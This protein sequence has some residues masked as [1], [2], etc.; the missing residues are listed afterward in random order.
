M[1]RL[2]WFGLA[3]AGVLGMSWAMRTRI[4]RAPGAPW[5]SGVMIMGNPIEQASALP[6]P[7]AQGTVRL[8]PGSQRVEALIT[9][10]SSGGLGFVKSYELKARPRL[11][12]LNRADSRITQQWLAGGRLPRPG[13]AE[14]LAGAHLPASDSIEVGDRKLAVVGVLRPDVGLLLESYILFSATNPENRTDTREDAEQ[15]RILLIESPPGQ[16]IPRPFH[17][18]I[19][20]LFPP[21]KYRRTASPDPLNAAAFWLYLASQALFLLGGSG[22]FLAVY[23]GLSRT[24]KSRLLAAPLM[25]IVRRPRLFWAVHA[26]YFGLVILGSV[27]IRSSPAFQSFM[28][29]AVEQQLSSPGVLGIA[30]KAYASQNVPYAAAV[31]FVINMFLGALAMI[32]LPAILIPGSGLIV[33]VGRALLWGILLAPNEASLAARMIAH[34]GTLLLEGEGYILAAFFGLLIP[35]MI[36]DR[37]HGGGVLERF[38]RGIVLNLKAIPLLALVLMVAAWYEAFE[39]IAQP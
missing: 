20:R 25:E 8:L 30:G 34:S 15:H 3:A 6:G 10:A 37:A 35:V 17:E 38:W 16:A 22:V 14:V 39:V 28:L 33:P 21:D 27:L 11:L 18:A 32:T 36:F 13:E 12:E 4:M 7:S 31:T 19:D 24:W 29:A 2:V 9:A 23:R 1:K 26:I 5:S